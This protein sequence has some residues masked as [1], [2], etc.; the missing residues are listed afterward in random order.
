M[1][2]ASRGEWGMVVSRSRY[3]WTG[4]RGFGVA[5]EEEGV[6]AAEGGGAGEE[7]NLGIER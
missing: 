6:V 1:R 2:T 3:V 4:R 5:E 7:V